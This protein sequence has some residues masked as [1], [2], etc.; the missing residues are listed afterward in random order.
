[1]NRRAPVATPAQAPESQDKRLT[2]LNAFMSCPH[3]DTEHIRAV[4]DEVRKQDPSFY[5]H[6]A[7]WYDAGGGDIRDHKE[8]F[9]SMLITD[10][11]TDNREV[12]LALFRDMPL[13]LKRRVV[14][15]IKGKKVKIRIK[16]GEKMRKA[17]KDIEMV[18]V[19]EKKVG[20]D[21]N[22]PHSLKTEVTGYLRW[23]EKDV[24][25]WDE[26][27]LRSY[28]DLKF[29]YKAGGLQVKPCPRA[30]EVL[31]E[32]KV[33]EGSKLGV[34]QLVRE[35]KTPEEAAKL[36]VEHK[37]PYTVAVGLVSKVTPTILVA[38]I[39]RM[40]SQELLN[41]MASLEEKGAMD[42]P[43][44]KAIIDKKLV[45][46]QTAKG[47]SALKSKTAT[48]TGRIKNAETVAK[49]DK[50][51]D[52]QI[53]KHGTITLPTAIFI[54]RSGSMTQAIEVG[55]RLATVVSGTTVADLHVVAFDSSAA[56]VVSKG[57]ELSDWEQAFKGIKAGGQTSIGSAL[58]LMLRNKV[59]VEQIV[60][61]TDE[62]ENAN[63]MFTDVYQKYCAEMKVK[64]HVV[65]IH[66]GGTDTT[67]SRNL[68]SAG[69]EF[70]MYTPEGN[71]YYG[72]PGIVTLLA[73]KSKLDLVYEI[74]DVPLRK[75]V[76][77]KG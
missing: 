33:P 7:C 36:I 43:E 60:V 48:A 15:F 56:E 1:M 71:D 46:A 39:E 69:I 59:Y 9:A 37:L 73:R 53:K 30:Q 26:A 20:L 70:D 28:W 66:V 29:L 74:M 18:R 44:V 23:L 68:K 51:A 62:G 75:R 13:F 17:G 65:V 4:H 77:F 52:K 3:R 2:L 12:G 58:Y 32:G 16:T 31:F 22:V 72:M 41:N 38:L 67:F 24:K 25:R 40:S 54:D 35:A 61:V 57:K 55:K 19:E 76:P 21:A 47:V 63:P 11:F 5:S 49:M 64:P 14:G 45:K 34:L 8:V 42:M 27:A 50:I 10:P 6:L